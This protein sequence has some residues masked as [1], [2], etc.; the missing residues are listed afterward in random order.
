MVAFLCQG[1]FGLQPANL[2]KLKQYKIAHLVYW[3]RVEMQLRLL[4]MK[5]DLRKLILTIFSNHSSGYLLYNYLTRLIRAVILK[6]P[7]G[8]ING[9]KKINPEGGF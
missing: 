4:Q 8:K 5:G 1:I 2:R 7:L 9:Y 3:K 6:A